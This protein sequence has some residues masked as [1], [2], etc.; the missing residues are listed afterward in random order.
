MHLLAKR[1]TFGFVLFDHLTQE[2]FTGDRENDLT[3]RLIGMR[4]GSF[5]N[6]V[7]DTLFIPHTLE[8]IEVLLLDPLLSTHIDFVDDVNKQIH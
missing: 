8:F 7:E 4:D 2:L 3:H 5:S 1:G 6:L